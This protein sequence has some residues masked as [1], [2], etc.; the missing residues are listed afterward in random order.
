[1]ARKNLLQSLMEDA[2]KPED[3]TTPPAPTRP[4][5]GAIGAVSQ[6]IEALKARSLVDI[7]PFLIDAGGLQDRLETD[8]AEDAALRTSIDTYGQQVPVLVRPHPDDPDRFQI[9]YGRRRVLALRDLG[10]PVKALVRD[11]DE[12]ALVMAQ[13]QENTAR[14]GLSF[15][16]KAN[17]A[18]QMKAADY[19]RKA[20]C[21]ALSIDKTVVSRMLNIVDKVGMDLIEIIGAAPAVGRD[22]WSAMAA[23]IEDADVDLEALAQVVGIKGHGCDSNQRFDIAMASLQRDWDDADKMRPVAR[24]PPK[25][26]PRVHEMKDKRTGAVYATIQDRTDKVILTFPR[27]QTDG[28]EEWLIQNLAQIHQSWATSQGSDEDPEQ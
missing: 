6:S 15:I 7:D 12:H 21:D 18:S 14:R 19:N 27:D 10:K 26:T 2:A 17:F 13:G 9:V 22:R 24:A 1:M 25:P 3:D 28:F 20:I 11:L 5:K 16:E 23:L 4:L 8:D